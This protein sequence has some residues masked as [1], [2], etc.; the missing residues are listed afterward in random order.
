[1]R[2]F[3]GCLTGHSTEEIP[4]LRNQGIHYRPFVWTADGR[5]HPA[6]TRTLQY[7]ADI[8][9]SRNGQQMSANSLQHKVETRNSDSPPPPESTD[10]ASSPATSRITDRTLN[11]WGRAMTTAHRDRHCHIER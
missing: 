7:A 1:M 8:A 6:V 10:D 2:S 4:D 11:H 9:P 5:P 3:H